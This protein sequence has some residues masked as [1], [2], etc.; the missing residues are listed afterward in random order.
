MKVKKNRRE[1][2]KKWLTLIFLFLQ[3]RINFEQQLEVEKAIT[4]RKAKTIFELIGAEKAYNLTNEIKSDDTSFS[5]ATDLLV[6]FSNFKV[7]Q[8]NNNWK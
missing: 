7:Y 6:N 3:S 2:K 4:I 1:R 8:L 5:T